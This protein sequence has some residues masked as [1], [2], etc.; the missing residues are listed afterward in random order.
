MPVQEEFKDRVAL[1]VEDYL[2][3]VISVVNELV[4]SPSKNYLSLCL[5]SVS[6][7]NDVPKSRLA[8][9]SV[10]LGNFDQPIKISNFVKEL[11]AGFSMVSRVLLSLV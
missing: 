6:P 3:G 9:N 5:S 10:T 4:S 1:P 7:V 11:F 2:H 8:V